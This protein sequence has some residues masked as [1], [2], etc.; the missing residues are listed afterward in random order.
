MTTTPTTVPASTGI[1]AT[2]TVRSPWARLAGFAALV[3]AATFV[4][5]I[6]MFATFLSDYTADDAT[7]A[8]SV[9]FLVEHQW[10]LH[11]WYIVILIVFGV[12]LV[13]LALG[14]HDRLKDGAP[15]L[16]RVATSFGL[17]WAGLVLAAGMV[18]N[19]GVGAVADLAGTDLDQATG[20]WLAL[21]AVQ[22]G[23]GGGNE[24]AG[25]VW[26]LL[27]SLAALR[28]HALPRW[29]G[30]LGI[31]SAAAGLVTVI[32]GLEGIGMVFGL[33]LVVWFAGVGVT[34]LRADR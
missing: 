22:D 29:L 33:G 28:T 3:E 27:V 11:L 9:A 10:S 20:L 34:L 6:A 24:V 2:P 23:L 21:E 4:I 14:L 26:L 12:A 31:A 19:V 16:A 25:G 17:V 13:P 18:A 30:T 8:S 15:A 1:D 32:P 5:G 7:P